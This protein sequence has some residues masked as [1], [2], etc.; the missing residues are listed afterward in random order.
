M[1]DVSKKVLTTQVCYGVVAER[2]ETTFELI[3][4][5]T[6]GRRKM[7]KCGL[8]V[9]LAGCFMLLSACASVNKW[10]PNPGESYQEIK[11]AK[12]TNTAFADDYKDKLVTF[13]AHF[14]GVQERPMISDYDPKEFFGITLI[15]MRTTKKD[16]EDTSPPMFYNILQKKNY[17]MVSDLK[18]QECVEVGGRTYLLTDGTLGIYIHKVKD[19][20]SWCKEN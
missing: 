13:K 4:I 9:I 19:I 20:E 7:K 16:K 17:S 18:N 5:T 14:M 11:R 2:I 8:Y 12:L 6:I 15:S 1:R 3:Q 10:G